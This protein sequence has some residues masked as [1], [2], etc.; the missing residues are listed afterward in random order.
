MRLFA[1][2][3]VGFNGSDRTNANIQ[4]LLYN[5][6]S[7]DLD[8]ASIHAVPLSHITM[9]SIT[10][11]TR[12]IEQINKTRSR[13]GANLYYLWRIVNRLSW[14]AEPSMPPLTGQDPREKASGRRLTDKMK[15]ARGYYG[16]LQPV[17]FGRKALRL[18]TWCYTQWTRYARRM[19]GP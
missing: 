3:P 14:T 11:I 4:N 1:V 7:W 13:I 16:A 6:S 8:L 18:A 9:L 5:A 10:W 2:W 17:Q 12:F 19:H 15:Q